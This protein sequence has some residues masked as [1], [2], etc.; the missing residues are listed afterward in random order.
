MTRFKR[1]TAILVVGGVAATIV[2]GASGATHFPLFGPFGG[3]H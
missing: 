2:V 3:A 1:L